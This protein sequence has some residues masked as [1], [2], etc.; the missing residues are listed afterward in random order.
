M[1]E[2]SPPNGAPRRVIPIQPAGGAR[3]ELVSLYQKSEKIYAREVKGWFTK[4]RW[5]MV[6]LTQVVFYCTPW[7][8]WNDR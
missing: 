8:M 6:W 2:T 5:A 4:W 7:L 1:S 3:E